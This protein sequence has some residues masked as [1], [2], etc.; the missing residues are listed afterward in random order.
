M[1]ESIRI[2]SFSLKRGV[3]ERK[4]SRLNIVYN[5][6][7]TITNPYRISKLRKLNGLDPEVQQFILRC[8]KTKSMLDKMMFSVTFGYRDIMIGC[9]GGKHRSVAM[10]ELLAQ[11]VR[12]HEFYKDTPIEVIHRD[13]NEVK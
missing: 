10:A 11:R 3:P 7:K 9:L 5:L 8:K 4:A 13:L 12:A 1:S 2:I 6:S